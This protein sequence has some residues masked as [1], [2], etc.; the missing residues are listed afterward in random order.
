MNR[1]WMPLYVGDYLADTLDLDAEQHGVYLLLLMMM[2]RRSDGALPDDMD[3]IKRS[4]SACADGMH[5]NR[6]NRLV[7]PLLGRF[8]RL[9]EDGN[10]RHKRLEKER[11]KADKF[12]EKQREKVGKRWVK[13][14][15]NNELADTAVLPARASQSQS[16]S[17]KKEAASAASAA[18]RARPSSKTHFDE[19]EQT[20]RE[21]LG[22]LAPVDLVI[23][24]A[25]ELFDTHGPP[26]AVAALL[27]AARSSRQPIRTWRL[28]AHRAAEQLAAPPI[29]PHMNGGRH[30]ANRKPTVSDV[31]RADIERLERLEREPG[32]LL[33]I[34][35]G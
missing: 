24:P 2:W 17:H 32:P 22:G 19:V 10:Y 27:D 15:K 30:E 18:A 1:A 21:V 13:P 29:Q 9:D 8:F 34:A 11:E 16:Q 12:S 33:R 28:L 35:S 6:F 3:F 20:C 25:V 23:G 31:L 4:L 14:N 5:G 26:K 7:P